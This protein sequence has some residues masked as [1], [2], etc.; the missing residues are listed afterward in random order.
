M[1]GLL[2]LMDVRTEPLAGETS[3]LVLV[4]LLVIVLILSVMFVASLVFFLI[5]YKRRKLGSSHEAKP[6]PGVHHLTQPE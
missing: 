4:S 2:A 3:G 1:I 5:W 6:A